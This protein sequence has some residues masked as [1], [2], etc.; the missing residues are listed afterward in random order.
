M[1]LPLSATPPSPSLLTPSSSSLASSSASTFSC[2][3]CTATP[4]CRGG[5][6]PSPLCIDASST[7]PLTA[8]SQ[9]HADKHTTRWWALRPPRPRHRTH[10]SCAATTTTND[11]RPHLLL[12][13]TDIC[14]Q[15][16]PSGRITP[17]PIQPHT[18]QPSI[19]HR[20]ISRTIL[21]HPSTLSTHPPHLS[22][23]RVRILR[24]CD[25]PS[26]C[27][28]SFLALRRGSCRVGG[29]ATR[30]LPYTFRARHAFVAHRARRRRRSL[31][32]PCR[33]RRSRRS[34]CHHSRTEK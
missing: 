31:H 27:E 15:A 20:P 2:P 4:L 29:C 28:P 5:R 26:R 16:P 7:T 21:S 33:R 12:L 3:D 19:I 6:Q 17:T 1:T 34:G 24:S 22:L 30:L 23:C 14:I 13:E 32:R 18:I 8:H 25:R 10:H 11:I 9:T